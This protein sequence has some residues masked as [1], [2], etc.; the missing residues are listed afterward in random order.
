MSRKHLPAAVPLNI[1]HRKACKKKPDF[2]ALLKS[3]PCADVR[4]RTNAGP[5]IV[6]AMTNDARMEF[7][8]PALRRRELDEL[9]EQ[10][11][12]SSADLV[13]LGIK[14]LLEHREVLLKPPAEITR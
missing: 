13:R 2:T 4:C 10:A 9:A 14:W 11:G 1:G 6:G 12:L 8:L 5:F 7:R 3:V